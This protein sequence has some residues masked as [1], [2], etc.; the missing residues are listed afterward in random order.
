MGV[1]K[2]KGLLN[3]HCISLCLWVSWIT[4]RQNNSGCWISPEDKNSLEAK[5][6]Q[7]AQS[8]A[9]QWH[10]ISLNSCPF[11]VGS[12]QSWTPCWCSTGRQ[13]NRCQAKGWELHRTVFEAYAWLETLWIC[14]SARKGQRE[15]AEKHYFVL[16]SS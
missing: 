14:S 7:W 12:L 16:K 6:C 15:C 10:S 13:S 11:P 8:K 1:E 3:L 4:A 2:K 5:H 9:E